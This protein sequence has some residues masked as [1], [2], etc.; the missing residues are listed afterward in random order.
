MMIM[1]FICA[2]ITTSY[3]STY[4]VTFDPRATYLLTNIDPNA[5]PAEVLDLAAFGISPGQTITLTSVGVIFFC[6]PQYCPQEFRPGVGAVF[7]SSSTLLSSNVL[8][9]V[10]GAIA[11]GTPWVSQ[12]TYFGGLSTDIGEDFRVFDPTSV[13]V[14]AGAKYL[15]LGIDDQYFGDNS[16]PNGDF[17]VTL[18][19]PVPE[20]SSLLLLASGLTFAIRRRITAR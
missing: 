18:Q 15:F 19:T 16:D 4:N 13:T 6:D 8:N 17:H 11:A 10:P 7:S 5:Q 12:P 1:V 9:R 20:P 3:A 14:P 2:G